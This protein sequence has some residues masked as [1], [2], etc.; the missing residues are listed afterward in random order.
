MD[1]TEEINKLKK[2]LKQKDEQIESL[3]IKLNNTCQF[4]PTVSPEYQ[5]PQIPITTSLSKEQISRYS[6]QL[7][8][9]EIAVKGQLNLINSSVLIV[10]A[11][12]LGSPAALF[13][14]AAGVG[15]IGII[16]YDNVELSN[17]HRQIIHSEHKI[18]IHKSSSAAHQISQ[19]NSSVRCIPY[20]ATIN[21]TNA[22]AL[23]SQ[24]DVILDC[25]DNVATRYLLNDAAVI[26]KRPLISG[27]ALRMEGQITTYNADQNAPCYRCLFPNP[28]PPHTVTN[29]SDGGV[30]GVVPG[31]I[32]SLQALEAINLIANKEPTWS[33]VMGLFDAQTGNL[34]RIKLRSR[35]S[36]CAV[37]GE[38]P[39]IGKDG[40]FD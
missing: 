7:M 35:Q 1:Q 18:N 3:Q 29:C 25:S 20:N 8:M 38:D 4:P 19:I 9:K 22:L 5:I 39:S 17:L 10:G 30:L 37:C 31:L 13:L 16:D 34:R 28:P 2:L 11:G 33:K 12:G 24:F 6:R 32:G 27:S 36:T 21:S 14:A 40:G 23:I 15:T 26:S